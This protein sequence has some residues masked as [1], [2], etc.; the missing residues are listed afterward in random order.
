MPI[1]RLIIIISAVLIFMSSFNSLVFAD[2]GSSTWVNPIWRHI[3][4][5]KSLVRFDASQPL[6]ALTT[7]T[8]YESFK[9][10]L[11]Q[12]LENRE[13]AFIINLL[14]SFTWEEVG[15]IITDAFD[16]IFAADGYIQGNVY[17]RGYSWSGT[18]GNVEITFTITYWTTYAQEQAVTEEVE[19]IVSDIITGDMDEEEKVKAVHDWIVLNVAYDQT[20]QSHSAYDAL[21]GDRETVCQGY[22][23]LAIRLF[24]DIAIES[25]FV[26]GEGNSGDGWGA[27]AW[28][29]VFVCGNWFHMDTTW[30]DPI[31]TPPDPDYIRWDY[32]L[33]SDETMDVDHNWEAADYPAAPADFT[34]CDTG[35]DGDVN[36]DGTVTMDDLILALKVCAGLNSIASIN[37]AADVNDD[38]RVGLQEILYILSR[39]AGIE[40]VAEGL[41]KSSVMYDAAPDYSEPDLEILVNGFSDFT[42]DFYHAVKNEPSSQGKNLFFSTYSIENALAMT[43]AGA[44]NRTADEMAAALHLNLPQDRFHHTLNALN[45]DINSRDDQPPFDGDAFSL[46]LV[47]AIWSRI[48]YPFLASYLDVLAENYDTG[49]RTLDFAGNPENSRRIINQWVEDQTNEKIKDLLPPNSISPNTA[50]VLTNA[51]YFKGSWYKKFEENETSPG[52][53]TRWD[54]ETVSAAMMHQR[55]D[56][57]YLQEAGFDALELP[58][59]SPR[60]EESQYPEELSMLIIIP[61]A[62]QS[63]SVE[64]SFESVENSLDHSS[65]DSIVSSLHRGDVILTFPKFEFESQVK[66]KQIMQQM[67]MTDAFNPSTADFSEMVSPTDSRPW[68]DEIYHKAFVA[69]DED[70]TEAAAAT[71]VVMNETSANPDPVT[72][73]VDRP[74][75]FLIRDDITGSILF[76]GRVL[77]PTS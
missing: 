48:G 75:I 11:T 61:N 12:R 63:E 65:L 13:T 62:G 39:M 74:F 7:C 44:K 46:N 70:G 58:Y 28:N 20:L 4:L 60:Y 52:T 76:M 10:E 49:V 5:E 3:P 30:D 34:V 16:E 51:I 9:S 31:I 47:N 25:R 14:Y 71:A 38:N 40:H 23:L 22:T 68:I 8:S 55:L 19:D 2:E 59:V 42:I 41:V 37:T 1:N 72:I 56:T 50:V 33:K 77:D 67:G 6:K 43:W 29:L 54:G 15:D 64:N 57:K 27:H 26:S 35:V 53:F 18:D 17:S 45:I 69:V 24:R 73:S 66:C 32:Y 36:G 21:F